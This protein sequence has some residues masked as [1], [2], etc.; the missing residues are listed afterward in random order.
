MLAALRLLL[1]LTCAAKAAGAADGLA[2]E[3]DRACGNA[4]VCEVLRGR[5]GAS[6]WL[7]GAAEEPPA[8]EERTW[9]F[10]LTG[11]WTDPPEDDSYG[12]A[13]VRADRGP[14]HLEAR[15]NYEDKDTGS[16]FAG[17]TFS[18]SGDVEFSLVPMLGGV[19]GHTQ[20]V[21]PGLELD[22]VWKALELYFEA[23]Y[24]FDVDGQ[25]DSFFYMWSELTV[26]PVEWFSFGLVAQRTRAYQTDV[27]VDRGLL[28]R[29]HVRAVTATVYVFNLD[30]DDPYVMVGVGV[31]F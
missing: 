28:V 16:V 19:F 12:S 20:G 13:I 30:Q 9:A 18:W 25:D 27:E 4:R 10:D 11:Y 2:R 7:V 24:V 6:R 14:L 8:E 31:S 22:L 17:W 5:D 15:Y 3:V 29:F 23:E 1:L 21:A 26:S